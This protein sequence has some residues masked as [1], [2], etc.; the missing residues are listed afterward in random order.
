MARKHGFTLVELLVVIAIIGLLVGLLLP[1]IQSAREAARR[2][3][4]SSNQRQLGMAVQNYESAF[5]TFPPTVTGY[6]YPSNARFGGGFYSWL[7]MILPQIEQGPLYN[8]IDFSAPMTSTTGGS[9]NYLQLLIQSNHKNAVVAATRISTFL[10]PSDPWVQTNYAGTAQ[11]APGSYA[12]NVG[13]TRATTGI[14][15][16]APQLEQS[17]GSMP[18]MNPGDPDKRWYTPKLSYKQI[19]DGSANTALI[20]ERV[21]N[22]LVPISG[23]FGSTMPRAPDSVLSYCGGGSATRSLPNW[24][25]YCEGVT[26]PDPTYSAPIGKAWISGITIAGNLYMH[27]TLPNT[28]NCHLYGGEGNGNNMIPA[29]SMHGSGFHM[30]YADGHTSFTSFSVEPRVWWSLGSRNGAEVTS[31]FE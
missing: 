21:I 15:G 10:C 4:C 19:T 7:A 13:W 24:V 5:K 8:Q 9:P 28:R 31:D 25:R 26:V 3:Q 20:A 12:G 18:I 30:T 14:F 2:M 29:S 22:S 1:A 11:P 27:V 6:G 16:D 17:N 23:P